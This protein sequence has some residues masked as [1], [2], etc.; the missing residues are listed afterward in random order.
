MIKAIGI[1]KSY[2]GEKVLKDVSLHIK[3]GERVAICEAR[4][5]FA[6]YL[7]G[8]R[9]SAAARGELNRAS[10]LEELQEIINGYISSLDI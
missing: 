3:K 10:T 9:G 7:K 5:H 4:K 2:N 6:W 8:E 1:E